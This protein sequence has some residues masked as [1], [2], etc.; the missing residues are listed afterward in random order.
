LFFTLASRVNLSLL[1]RY[2]LL[3]KEITKGTPD[4][5]ADRAG[6]EEAKTQM[7]GLAKLVNETM[8]DYETVTAFGQNLTG[9]DDGILSLFVFHQVCNSRTFFWLCPGGCASSS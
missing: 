4:T 7:G 6:L 5:H 9:F 8:R 1:C 3:L 2:P